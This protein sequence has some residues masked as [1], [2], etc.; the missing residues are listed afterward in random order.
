MKTVCIYTIGLI[1]SAT[2]ASVALA[3]RGV[4]V[5]V[6]PPRVGPVAPHFV[7]TGPRH[8]G[9]GGTDVDPVV[10]FSIVG[11][12]VVLVGGVL[13]LVLW[14]RKHQPTV[15]MLRIVQVPPGEAP[16]EIRRA[17]V[18]IELPLTKA[19]AEPRRVDS[20]GAVTLA[21]TGIATGYVVDGRKA[22]QA[23][24][25]IA[26]EAALWWRK[27]APHVV[28]SGYQLLFPVNVCEKLSL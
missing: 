1:L 20:T 9:G 18:G 7:P 24:E 4:R 12:I 19:N 5:P 16:E 17:W 15:A 14:K 8:A 21:L 23:L 28:R 11:G 26:P 6:S 10:V 22:V 25:P 27:N 2:L 13:L 3:Q